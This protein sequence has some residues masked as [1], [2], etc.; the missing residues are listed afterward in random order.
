M[1]IAQVREFAYVRLSG[2]LCPSVGRTIVVRRRHSIRNLSG[3][4]NA[5]RFGRSGPAGP[6]RR[7]IQIDQSNQLGSMVADVGYIEGEIVREGTLDAQTPCGDIG[8]AQFTV[9]TQ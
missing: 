1:D 5:I 2:Y 9:H 3:T 6:D 8:R 4:V 7:L